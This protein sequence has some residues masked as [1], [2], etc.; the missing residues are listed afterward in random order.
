ME[1]FQCTLA[2]SSVALKR[3]LKMEKTLMAAG[4]FCCW[5]EN[6]GG[7]KIFAESWPCLQLFSNAVCKW[8]ES[9]FLC[10][11]NG[12]DVAILHCVHVAKVSLYGMIEQK[13][14]ELSGSRFV[15]VWLCL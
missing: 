2:F 9:S 7:Y 5:M 4:K 6:F 13:V 14:I 15:Q 10:P 1:N 11:H 12:R 3:C 8:S